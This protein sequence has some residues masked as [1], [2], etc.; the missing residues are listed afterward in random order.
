[1][2][3]ESD[4]EYGGAR[5]RNGLEGCETLVDSGDKLENLGGRSLEGLLLQCEVVPAVEFIEHPSPSQ[6][7]PL[8]GVQRS[9]LR[10]GARAAP[11][12]SR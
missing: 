2:A 8:P 7:L 9:A 10:S 11:H 5:M 1:M 6:S 4:D 12:L 3:R